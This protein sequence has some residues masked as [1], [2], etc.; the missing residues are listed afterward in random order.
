MRAVLPR[1]VY[2]VQILKILRK[3]SL[4]LLLTPALAYPVVVQ[5][6]Y[7]ANVPVEDHSSAQLQRATSAG[8]AQVL[9][10]LS[11]TESVLSNPTVQEALG[12]ARRYMQR[13]QYLRQDDDSLRL[14]IHYD[15]QLVT[16][17]V[18]GAQQP[19][20]TANRPPLLVWLVVD[21]GRGRHFA[22]AETDPELIAALTPELERR[23]VPAVFPLYDLEDALALQVHDLW[24][25][26]ALSI[27]K[28]S[29]RYD[30]GNVLAGRMT[31]VSDGRW[32]GDWLYLYGKQESS[33]SFYGREPAEISALAVD[34]VADLMAARYAVAPGAAQAAPVL[35]Q[36]DA[37]DDYRAYRQVLAYLQGIELVEAVWPAFMEDGSIVFRLT[38]QAD[39]EQ[40]ERIIALNRRLQRLDEPRPLTHGPLNTGLAYRWNP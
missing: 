23:G 3:I 13:Y 25:M 40:L 38:A 12:Q 27:L 11:G 37:L 34:M 2:I 1:R 7:R 5:N 39:A 16:D 26:D 30:V 8:L 6:L 21:D 20:W 15:D 10:K 32:M 4:V 33:T 28:A 14:E 19:L 17:L 22:T 24:S 31:A 29:R 9:V 35:I 36:V 18:T